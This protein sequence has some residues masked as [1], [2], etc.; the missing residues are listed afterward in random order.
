MT[1]LTG[2]DSNSVFKSNAQPVQ[3]YYYISAHLDIS[4][5][6]LGQTFYFNKDNNLSYLDPKKDNDG[7][8]YNYWLIDSNAVI[9]D[10]VVYSN[11]GLL[12]GT[13][14][15]PDDAYIWIGGADSM[16]GY[17]TGP[18]L[19]PW[20]GK[21]GFSAGPLSVNDVN[22]ANVCYFGHE[23]GHDIFDDEDS[24]L[25][26][27]K[28]LAISLMTSP[29]DSPVSLSTT[30]G[31]SVSQSVALDRNKLPAKHSRSALRKLRQVKQ[32]QDVD[33]E[34]GTVYVVVKVYPK[35]Q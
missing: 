31:K 33:I 3:P 20:A 27:K 28:V 4:G 22:S 19:Q 6:Q 1:D 29:L 15:Q 24:E 30:D 26:D 25:H 32:V 12:E 5:M 34:S 10:V 18:V 35:F 8:Y 17:P 9:G 14:I 21:T 13:N 16:D 7:G 23:G 2:S 11:P